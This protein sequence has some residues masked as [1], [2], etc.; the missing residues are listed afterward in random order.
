[1]SS[2]MP[3]SDNSNNN[4]SA[5]ATIAVDL[6][7]YAS[8]YT[9]ITRLQ[10]LLLIAK[11]TPSDTVSQQAFDLAEQQLRADGN[12]IQYQQTFGGVVAASNNNQATQAGASSGEQPEEQRPP[13]NNNEAVS[14]VAEAE[15]VM[16][17][18]PMVSSVGKYTHLVSQ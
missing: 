1:M 14:I 2:I 8:R 3:S 4:N 10:R 16:Q 15:E 7:T 6:E 9:G 11:T 13:T 5:T 17:Q 18:Q 12:V